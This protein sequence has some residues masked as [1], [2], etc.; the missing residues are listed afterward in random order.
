M[1]ISGWYNKVY[2]RDFK[3]N[4]CKFD[5]MGTSKKFEQAS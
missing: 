3:T 1:Q 4:A 5:S 2:F